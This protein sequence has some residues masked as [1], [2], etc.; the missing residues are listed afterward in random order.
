MSIEVMNEAWE[1]EKKANP[2]TAYNS[3]CRG[4]EA[5]RKAIASA[6]KQEPRCM[7][8]NCR[9][10]NADNHSPECILETAEAQGWSDAPEAIKARK[11][12]EA[13]EKQEPDELTVAYMSGFYDGKNKHAPRREW[14]GLTDEDMRLCLAVADYNQGR[15]KRTQ[16]WAHLATAIEAKLREKNK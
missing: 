13:A 4:Y 16:Y 12:I 8:T 1:L 9:M 7:G 3:W 14:V 10:P 2:G 11:A 15:Y 6:E 5:G